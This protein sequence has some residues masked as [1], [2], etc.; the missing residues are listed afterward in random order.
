[1]TLE[2]ITFDFGNTLVPVPG[3]GPARRGRGARR[4]AIADAAGAVRR[5]RGAPRPGPRSASA[6]SA[7]RSRSSARSTSRS[8]LV[9]VLAR[10]R[11]HAAA[12]RPTCAGTTTAAA[13]SVDPD[14]VAWAV[15]VYSRAFVASLPPAPAAGRAARARS[16]PRYRARDP[17]ELAAGG[18]HRP[19][20]RGRG[21]GAVPRGDRR[22]AAGRH[23]QAAPGDLRGGP[24]RRSAT[25]RRPRSSTSATTGRRTSSARSGRAGGRRTSR[26]RPDDSPLPGSE[27]DDEATAGPGARHA[28]RAGGGP[29]RS[30]GAERA[31]ARDDRPPWPDRDPSVDSAAMERRDRL[32]NLGAAGRGRRWRGSWSP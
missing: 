6:S 16:P 32:A 31:R 17:V 14:E 25:R 3:G 10:L 18:D 12:G 27:R 13:R 2:A 30:P 9:R 21:L 8:A 5:G 28:R 26:D 20:R 29:R 7:R 19:L 15:D 11:G 23:D 4:R 22:L 1:M 24:R